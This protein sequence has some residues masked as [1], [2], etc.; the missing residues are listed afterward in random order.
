MLTITG[1]VAIADGPPLEGA[2]VLIPDQGISVGTNEAGRYTIVVRADR[3]RGQQTTLR[4]RAVG[5]KPQT[6][7]G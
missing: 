2:N 4:V 7:S 5:Y 1:R 6:R 3:L